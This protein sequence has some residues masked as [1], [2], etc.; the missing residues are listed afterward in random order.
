MAKMIRKNLSFTG[1][2]VSYSFI[3]RKGLTVVSGDSSTGKTLF[4]KLK[5]LEAQDEGSKQYKFINYNNADE[6]QGII[7]G[8]IHDKIVFI[9]NA[10]VIIP[11]EVDCINLFKNSTNQFVVF[12]RRIARY[13]VNYD[14]WAKLVEEEKGKIELKYI[15]KEAGKLWQ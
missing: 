8:T 15:I 4:F 12:G 13:D 5:Q 1:E 10:D 3:V 2:F 7:E 14:N 6:L 11:D 9:D